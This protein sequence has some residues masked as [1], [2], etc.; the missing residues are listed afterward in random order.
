MGELVGAALD[1]ELARA[2]KLLSG[3][4]TRPTFA[5]EEGDSVAAAVSA[6]ARREGCDLIALPA[7]GVRP[8]GDFGRR[9]ERVLVGEAL[10][11]V[12]RMPSG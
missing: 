7:T 5:R 2:A 1:D 9:T 3:A 12:L 8:G 4:S 10:G 6:Y 11:P